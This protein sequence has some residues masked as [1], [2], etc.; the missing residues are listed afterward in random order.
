MALH[1][2]AMTGGGELGPLLIPAPAASS[3]PWLPDSG[4]FARWTADSVLRYAQRGLTEPERS[5]LLQTGNHPGRSLVDAVAYAPAL[6]PWAALRLPLSDGVTWP[7]LPLPRMMAVRDAARARLLGAVIP[8]VTNKHPAADSIFRAVIGYGY[9]LRED[10]DALIGALVGA[11]IMR[12]AGLMMAAQW[13]TE[14]KLLM[15]DSLVAALTSGAWGARGTDTAESPPL[16]R[17]IVLAAARDTTAIRSVRWERLAQLGLAP[18]TD[19]RELLYGP[20]RTV[21]QTYADAASMAKRSP[22]EEGAYGVLS[23][24]IQGQGGVFRLPFIFKPVGWVLGKRAR[25][26]GEVIL[27]GMM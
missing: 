26:C 18:C 11:S 24:G 23:R 6:D 19:L 9:R 14:G 22:Q 7:E 8:S 4:P 16:T 27:G 2:I 15:A 10:S 1:S 20:T 12:E 17:A 21:R 5:W 13:R 3:R 25:G